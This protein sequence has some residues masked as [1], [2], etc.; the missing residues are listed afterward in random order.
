MGVPAAVGVSGRV[1]VVRPHSFHPALRV[2][3][4][5]EVVNHAKAPRRF[6]SAS[7]ID[8]GERRHCMLHSPSSAASP[9]GGHKEHANAAPSMAADRVANGEEAEQAAAAGR[10][11]PDATGRPQLC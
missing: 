8:K 1:V 2:K 11:N 4:V 10:A 5:L 3:R 7:E 9:G 6:D